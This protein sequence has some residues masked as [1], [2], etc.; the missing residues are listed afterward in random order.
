MS[1]TTRYLL[2]ILL[3]LIL[4][5]V[6]YYFLCCCPCNTSAEVN[7]TST[8]TKLEHPKLQTT[9]LPFKFSDPIN[10]MEFNASKNYNFKASS[11]TVLKPKLFDDTAAEIKKLISYLNNNPSKQLNI[12]GLYTNK[13]SNPS[14]YPNLGLARANAVKNTL[15]QQG[16]S[17]KS[18]N[19]FAKENNEMV[20]DSLNIYHG[21]ITYSISTVNDND[22]SFINE[23]KRVKADI[24]KNPLVMHFDIGNTSIMLTSEQREKIRKIVKC[25]DKIDGSTIQITGHTDN[26]GDRTSNITLGKNRANFAKEHFVLN[27]ISAS[28]I[29]TSSKGP[30]EPIADNAT[31]EG[32]AKNRRVIVTIN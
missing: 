17:S 2:G 13:D 18:L 5:T 29:I 8:P 1:K 16:A 15:I 21:P 26:T 31:K 20:P 25:I 11:F 28:K 22:T 9:K 3:T 7:K 12:T 14:V 27:G 6:L 32:R 24:K 4:G 30:D 19:T 10:K 23:L